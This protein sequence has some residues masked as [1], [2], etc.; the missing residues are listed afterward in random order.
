MTKKMSKRAWVKEH[1]EQEMERSIFLY[2]IQK[3]LKLLSGEKVSYTINKK[4]DGTTEVSI[5][6]HK[7]K[8]QP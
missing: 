4:D 6:F 5:I 2:F 1:P 8:L 7:Q 3:A